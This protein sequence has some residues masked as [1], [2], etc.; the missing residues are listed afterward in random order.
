MG[1]ELVEGR[2]CSSGQLRSTCAPPPGPAAG[3]DVIYRR[4]DDDFLDPLA[5]RPDSTLGCAGPAVRLPRRQRDAG[6][7]HR[8]RRRRRQVDLPYVPKMVEFYL[9]EKPILQQRADLPVPR[10]RTTSLRARPP[11]ELVVKE[12][13][14]AGGYGMLSARRRRRPRSPTS[15]ARCSPTRPATSRSRRWRCRPARPSSSGIAP[16]H[17]DLRPFVL[18]GKRCRWCPAA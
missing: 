15:A 11:A 18:S 6:Q 3:V 4:I 2:T 8:H 16:R 14:G 10:G 7:R 17:I 5:F 12:V 13:H 9:G 1:I